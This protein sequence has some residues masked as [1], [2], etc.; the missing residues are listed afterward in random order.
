MKL[1]QLI[2]QYVGFRRGLGAKFEA[3][4]AVLHTFSRVVGKG[5]NIRN[6][7]PLEVAAFLDGCGVVTR[8]WQRKY[9]VLRGFFRYAMNRGY[10]SA[11]PLPATVPKLP[12]RFKPYIYSREDLRRL[13]DST[14]SAQTRRFQMEA[15]TFR[16]LLLLLYGAGLRVSEA[17]SLNLE[18]VDLQEA[19]I[20]IRGTKFFKTRLVPLGKELNDVIAEY[21][22]QRKGT[23]HSPNSDAPFFVTALG[24]RLGRRLLERNFQ[25]LRTQAGVRRDDGARYQPRLHDLRH[26]AA[27]HRLTAWYREG[28]DVQ[29]LLPLLSTYLGHTSIACT[30]IYLT[31][32][33][34]LLHEGSKR[35]ARYV[36]GEVGHD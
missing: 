16:T 12:E 7:K 19:V 24:T 13:L 11:S 30:Q 27:V 10:L 2:A 15:P 28:Q 20:I 9:I 35:F 31:L 29:R 26:A 25:R 18:D 34:D 22:E 14:A 23:G 21:A 5:R 36:F 33:P 6:V 17:L 32:T 4:E 1:N 3:N 8:Y